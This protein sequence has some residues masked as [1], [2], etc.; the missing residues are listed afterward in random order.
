MT[1]LAQGILVVCVVAIT[2]ALVPTLL[3]IWRA[4][5]R[6]EAVLGE[7]ERQVRPLSAEVEALTREVRGLSHQATV[8]LARVSGVLQGLED[9]SLKIGRLA[10]FALGVTRVGQMAGLAAGLKS[11]A[12]VF[13]SRLRSRR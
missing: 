10:G 9:V 3:A 6:A 5:T 8:E 2:I 4:A 7:V 13:V 11:G 12:S 1:P